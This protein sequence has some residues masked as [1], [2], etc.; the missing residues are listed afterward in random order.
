MRESRVHSLAKV[1][2]L[3]D[4]HR[5]DLAAFLTEDEKGKT[6][7]EYIVVLARTLETERERTTA[8]LAR[9]R[10]RV[11]LISDVVADQQTYATGKFLIEPVDLAQLADDVLHL[12]APM[13]AAAGIRVTRQFHP[14][15]AVPVHKTKLVHVLINLIKNAEEAL[16]GTAA[17]DR[18]I[19]I[20]I[21]ADADG[22]PFVTVRDTGEGIA[23]DHLA[24][25]FVHGF[26]TKPTGH[27]F[28]LHTCANS[29]AEMGGAITAAS[30]GRGL[31]ASFTLT[32]GARSA[33]AAA[34]PL[35]A[36]A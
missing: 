35:A 25:V 15:A 34:A 14:G 6:L 13:L 23:A 29:M 31:G 36:T 18:A 10:G 11:G 12:R 30:P 20:A 3:I 16:A 32:F 9:L 33:A 24:Q 19:A 4:R 17:S 27:G 7:A 1:G 2:A 8:E 21:G 26:T 28:G 22:H 5:D